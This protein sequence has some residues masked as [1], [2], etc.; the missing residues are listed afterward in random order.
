M[1]AR[2]PH[3]SWSPITGI[4]LPWLDAI[5]HGLDLIE[6]TDAEWRDEGGEGLVRE[7][8]TGCVGP[9]RGVSVATKMLHLK[10]PA[11]FPVIDQ[12]VAEMVGAPLSTEAP[13]NVRAQQATRV[14]LHLR[15]EGRRNIE[16][17]RDIQRDLESAG[18]GRSLVRILD[19]VLWSSHPAAG[20]KAARRVLSCEL[21]GRA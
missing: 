4:E 11:L 17:L 21:D 5:P 19:A 7:A 13:P 1:R 20:S 16:A 15:G 3:A 9:G 14:V 18:F 2:T 10:R 8:I 12:L 6:P